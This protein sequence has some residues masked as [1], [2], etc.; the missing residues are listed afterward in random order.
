MENG[1]ADTTPP[2][3]VKRSARIRNINMKRKEN[4]K[5]TS[6]TTNRKKSRIPREH[7]A[8]S[9]RIYFN[10]IQMFLNKD[11]PILTQICC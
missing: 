9:V 2:P 5:K 10:E 11:K 3:D 7:N 6:D 8:K 1:F 4:T